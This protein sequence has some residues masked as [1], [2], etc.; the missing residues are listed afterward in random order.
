MSDLFVPYLKKEGPNS[1]NKVE[2]LSVE[3][4]FGPAC[5][6]ADL[7]HESKRAFLRLRPMR[8]WAELYESWLN[9]PHFRQH[10]ETPLE[11]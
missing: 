5:L 11:E 10:E 2:T 7:D 4:I 1:V 6:I 3:T 9:A 8:E